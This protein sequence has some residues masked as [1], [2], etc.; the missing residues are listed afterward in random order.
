M[1][2]TEVAA[3]AQA[4]DDRDAAADSLAEEMQAEDEDTERREEEHEEEEEEEEEEESETQA[5]AELEEIS[6]TA[7]GSG[8]GGGGGGDDDDSGSGSGR[9]T[10]DERKTSAVSDVV[11]VERQKVSVCCGVRRRMIVT[12]K[13]VKSVCRGLLERERERE[14]KRRRDRRDRRELDSD[15]VAATWQHTSEGVSLC[16]RAEIF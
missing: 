8:G 3:L 6:L 4:A 14:E 9:T 7:N 15:I 16:D 13:S 10:E 2:E 11:L 1:D 5:M 12:V